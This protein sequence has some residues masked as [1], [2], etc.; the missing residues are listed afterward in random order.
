M[1]QCLNKWFSSLPARFLFRSAA[2]LQS[3]V[4]PFRS[5]L[6]SS[7]VS[8]AHHSLWVYRFCLYYFNCLLDA[9]HTRTDTLSSTPYITMRFTTT[10]MALAAAA[11][12]VAAQNKCD[13]QKYVPKFFTP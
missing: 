1:S 13:A 2:F 6:S 8:I 10:L 12:L 4:Q 3:L 5:H 7:F 11:G 9:L